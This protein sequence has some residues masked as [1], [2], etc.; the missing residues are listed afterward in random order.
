MSRAAPTSVVLREPCAPAAPL[1]HRLVDDELDSQEIEA[2][3][4][5]TEHCTACREH[6]RWLFLQEGLLLSLCAPSAEELL[7]LWENRL[8]GRLYQAACQEAADRLLRWYLNG[9]RRRGTHCPGV[10]APTGLLAEITS[11]EAREAAFTSE[12]ATL[13]QLNQALEAMHGFSP[14]PMPEPSALVSADEE[15]VLAAFETI[16]PGWEALNWIRTLR[17]IE[18]GDSRRARALYG[19]L[20]GE[21]PPAMRRA[22]GCWIEGVIVPLPSVL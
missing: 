18:E 22:L 20:S 5:H 7:R 6:L 12:R 19:Q 10:C 2:V 3:R 21:T 4:R 8:L 15:A 9:M 17:A 11:E 16:R 1:L 13:R 14:I